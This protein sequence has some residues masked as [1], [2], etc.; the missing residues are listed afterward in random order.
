MA[1]YNSTEI[2]TALKGSPVTLPASSNSGGI[3][4]GFNDVVTAT[5][6]VVTGDILNLCRIPSDAVIPRIW[7]AWDDFGTTAPADLGFYNTDGTVVDIDALAT[8]VVL[9][10]ASTGQELRYEVLNINTAG[11]KA[12]QLAG[13]TSDPGGQYDIAWTFGTV[14]AGAIGDLAFDITIQVS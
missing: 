2:M 11:Q 12:W 10:T 5:T 8:A 6:A 7:C 1:T 3:R 13:A 14:S 9:A 4:R